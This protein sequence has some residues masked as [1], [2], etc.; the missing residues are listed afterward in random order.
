L[1]RWVRPEGRLA[2]SHGVVRERVEAR[3][4][5]GVP[6]LVDVAVRRLDGASLCVLRELGDDAVASEA[7]RRFDAAFDHA[8]IG[9]ALFNC[10]GEYVR[11]N[12]AL[13]RLLGR[14]SAELIGRRDQELT[15]PDDR[16]ADIEVAWEILAGRYDSHQCEKRFVRPDGSIVW[17]LANLTFLRDEAGRPLTWVGQFQDITA[18]RAAEDALRESEERFRHAFAYAPIGMALVSPEGRWLRVNRT[19]CE[20]VGYPEAE[21]LATSFQDITHPDDLH[22][23]VD[24]LHRMVAGEPGR[25]EIEKRYVRRDG[26]VVWVQLS[27][28]LVRREDGAPQLSCRRS[29]TSAHASGSMA[30]SSTSPVTTR[31]PER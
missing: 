27:V 15:H 14:S 19:L 2:G 12:D 11:V 5:N 30:G 16:Q 20:I 23:D 7:Q 17:A 21:L 3:R 8:P 26:A 29:R 9:M 6:F 24:L 22:G 28:S 10:D 25:H 4:A 18:R 13:C 1:E 31:S